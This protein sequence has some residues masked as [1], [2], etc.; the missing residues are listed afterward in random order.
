MTASD[1]RNATL[2][3]SPAGRPAPAAWPEPR[4]ARPHLGTVALYVVGFVAAQVAA[5]FLMR[6]QGVT[7]T[8][9]APN[10]IV[11]GLALAH[12]HLDPVPYFRHDLATHAVFNWA[13]GATLQTSGAQLFTG[14]HGTVPAHG[15]GLSA[16]LVPGLL[17]GGVPAALLWLFL[18]TAVGL[19]YLHQR[20]SHLARLGHRAQA[21]FALAMAAPAAVLASTQVY[22]DFL[23]GVLA[24]CAFVEIAWIERQRRATAL[25]AAVLAVAFAALPWLE[26]KNLV[27]VVIGVLALAAA[28]WRARTGLRLAGTVVG[29]TVVTNGLL[30]AYNEYFFA[31]AVGL[32]ETPERLNAASLLHMLALV[33]DRH[34]GLVVQVPT[35]LVGLVGLWLARR[36]HPVSATAAVLGAA[37]IV[38]LNGAYG[39]QNW[40]GGVSLAGRFEWSAVPIL[41]AWSP[42]LLRS[43]PWRRLTVLAAAIG[44]LWV[45]QAVPLLL[46]E[47]TY[48]NATAPPFLPWDPSLYP[49]WWP[50]ANGLLPAFVDVGANKGP[51]VARAV[52]EIVVLAGA[53]AVLLLATRPRPLRHLVA[54]VVP[55]AAVTAGTALVAGAM[56]PLAPATWSGQQLGGPWAHPAKAVAVGP[57]PL[58]VVGTGTYR[59]TITYA[60]AAGAPGTGGRPRFSVLLGPDQNGSWAGWFTP[61]HPTD[62][63]LLHYIP[64]S[65]TDATTAFQKGLAPAGAPAT[66]TVRFSVTRPSRLLVEI[67]VPAGGA[68]TLSQF[69]LAKVS[70]G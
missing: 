36:S 55:V 41:L 39:S 35:V 57:L 23:A 30:L 18:V 2:D 28:C 21:V 44:G 16:L 34:Q 20:A 69:Q 52:I 1:L 59:A 24:A 40:T 3:R 62:A 65:T 33:L 26:I 47:H 31:H 63:A 11:A 61:R 51:F 4:Y 15:I 8:G 45:W 53:A 25:N 50:G 48:I 38:V 12:L 54:V 49:G 17:A 43:V 5:W 70:A 27:L 58:A 67:S 29:L 68:L 32:P 9:D 56:L 60:G 22:P 14:P 13:P 66:T 42:F 19:A 64:P 37:S 10:Y 46:A 6:S 7:I